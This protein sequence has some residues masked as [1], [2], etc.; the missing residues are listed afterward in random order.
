V[1]LAAVA[2]KALALVLLWLALASETRAQQSA[3]TVEPPPAAPAAASAPAVADA[4]AQ[5]IADPAS[6]QTDDAAPAVRLA[7]VDPGTIYWQRFG[8]NA[9]LIGD[10]DAAIAY[11]FGYFD[12]EQPD[13]LPRFLSGRMLYQ[14]VAFPA[15]EDLAGYAA[16]QRSVHL[17]LLDLAPAQARRLAGELARA[18]R[19]DQ[20]DYLY[21]YFR[22]NCSTRLRDALDDALD[23]SLRTQ[24]AGRSRGYTY[25]MHALRLADGLPWMALGI[26]LGLGPDADR[27]LS[28]WD[29]MFIPEQLRRNLR[30][31]RSADGGPLVLEEGTWFDSGQ[32]PPPELPRDRRSAFALTGLALAAAAL[33]LGGQA[34]RRP[35]ARRTLAWTAGSLHLLFGL[36]GVVLLLLWLA[37]DHVAAHGN[38]NL[39]LLSPLSLLLAV[40]WWLRA[41]AGAAAGRVAGSL[42]AVVAGSAL[43]GLLAKALPQ[44]FPQANLHWCLLLVPLHLALAHAWRRLDAP[45]ADLPR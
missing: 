24:T 37:T 20:R 28:F 16:E 29:E 43:L 15:R 32:A 10:D 33:W 40:P 41:R 36:A 39:F 31:V 30:E 42:A 35:W 21:E 38:E 44:V 4:D 19:P 13:F 26:D 1:A 7:T 18:V 25:R 27:R 9:L 34:R 6:G 12:F 17:Q 23:G 5:P 3:D 45:P 2:L 8:H 11:N 14:A 22:A